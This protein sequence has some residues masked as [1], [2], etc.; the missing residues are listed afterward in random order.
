MR[1]IHCDDCVL[2][3]G[4]SY[5]KATE[6]ILKQTDRRVI[7]VDKNEEAT[8]STTSLC[9][10]AIKAD[11]LHVYCV[12]VL[13][14]PIRCIQ[15]GRELGDKITVFV[16]IGGNR[17]YPSVLSLVV[18][19]L[20]ELQPALMVVKCRELYAAAAKHEVSGDG[21]FWERTLNE[22]KLQASAAVEEVPNPRSAPGETRIC[23]AFLKKGICKHSRCVFRH[24]RP[25]HPDV[26]AYKQKLENSQLNPVKVPLQKTKAIQSLASF[27]FCRL[28]TITL[29]LL[30][31]PWCVHKLL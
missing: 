27:D 16:D 10:D 23:H 24:L 15:L 9:R 17:D 18:V 30:F 19:L 5:G 26:I 1:H 21:N 12:D 7:A 3:I 6:I 29:I 11:R 8:N 14:N 13:S 31:V 2:E 22:M 4:C 28:L 25:L 20:K